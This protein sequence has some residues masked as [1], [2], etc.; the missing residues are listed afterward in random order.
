MTYI[1]VIAKIYEE[2]DSKSD[3]DSKT[4]IEELKEFLK[5]CPSRNNTDNIDVSV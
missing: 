4:I 3:V 1:E 2:S 5:N